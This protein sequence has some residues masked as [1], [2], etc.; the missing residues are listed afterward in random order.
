MKMDRF[1]PLAT[2]H[3]SSMNVGRTRGTDLGET[4]GGIPA[5]PDRSE[6]AFLSEVI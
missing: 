3:A 6:E 1:R 5:L 2:I 4:K